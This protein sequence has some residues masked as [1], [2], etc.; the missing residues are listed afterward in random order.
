MGSSPG[1]AFALLLGL[2]LPSAG[3]RFEQRATHT[4]LPVHARQALSP[5][6]HLD[7]KYASMEGPSAETSF[8]LQP[9]P[10]EILWITAYRTEVV[11]PD[12]ESDPRLAEFMCHNNMDFDAPAHARLFG[13]T[14]P[15]NFGRAFT[16]SQGVFEIEFPEGYGMPLLSD[17]RVTLNTMVLNH[18][19]E[20][21][22]FNVRH[23]VTIEYVKDEDAAGVLRPVYPVASSVMALV[24]GKTA[25]TASTTSRTQCRPAR[26]A[27]R[28]WW[29]P[30]RQ[31]A[32]NTTP[33]SRG[34]GSLHIGWSPPIAS[35]DA[36]W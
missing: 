2:L 26:A 11:G 30:T 14:R 16:A 6:L 15:L 7:G 34:A 25:T 21:A 8:T 20:D 17:E 1:L 27:L 19:V 29:R 9:G 13:L 10:R 3:C 4:G 5:P 35:F 36:R 23:R 33:T 24:Q 18:N 22:D 31:R 32:P 28:G 12:G